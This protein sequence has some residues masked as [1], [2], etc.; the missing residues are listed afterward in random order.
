M[1]IVALT[2]IVIPVVLFLI[3]RKKYKADIAPFFVGCAVFIV[4]A[5]LLEGSINSLIFT[6]S[7]GKAIQSNIWFYGIFGGL[8]A[9]LFE[10]TGRFTV[11]KTI[12]KKNCSNNR[13]ALMYGA[14][15][16]GIEAFYILVFGMVSNIVMA[17]M[18]NADMAEKLTAGVTDEAKLQTLYTIFAALAGTAP[19]AFLMSIVERIAALVLHVSLSV[20]V[21]F[22]AKNGGKCF[23]F[24]PLALLLHAT[25]NSVAVI[26]SRYVS[27]VWIIF[28]V[29]YVL[30]ACCVVIAIT[31]WKKY[32]SKS[33][34]IANIS[35]DGA[36]EAL[37]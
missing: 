33:G 26:L 20:L 23:W 9:G 35:T 34:I 1:T 27:S 10:E 37:K 14:G 3:F 5:L 12:L 32:S 15:H 7:A 31:V 30:S 29:I 11:F 2:G 18:L 19:V 8:M 21:W 25:V 22:A 28:I 17:V 6:S 36:V 24:Y 16:G 13:N 4:F